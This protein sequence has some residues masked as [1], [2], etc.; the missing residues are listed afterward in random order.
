MSFIH[1]DAAHRYLQLAPS[2][3]ARHF[4]EDHG[5]LEVVL[6]R[7]V[8]DAMFPVAVMYLADH[9]VDVGDYGTTVDRDAGAYREMLV[10]LMVHDIHHR[11]V[12][13]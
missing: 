6:N 2:D 4:T 9:G 7:P 12:E 8:V 3:V 13:E 5:E 10:A 1:V 11:F